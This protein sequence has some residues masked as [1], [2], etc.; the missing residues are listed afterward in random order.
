[1]KQPKHMHSV[2]DFWVY[3]GIDYRS[4]FTG[5][6]EHHWLASPK[7]SGTYRRAAVRVS[8][9]NGRPGSTAKRIG[10]RQWKVTVPHHNPGDG[11]TRPDEFIV[12]ARTRR[13]ALLL[14]EIYQ[15]YRR[16]NGPQLT[17]L[18]R[19]IVVAAVRV[20]GSVVEGTSDRWEIVLPTRRVPAPP[21][22][23]YE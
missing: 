13:K 21:K 3:Y 4:I 5:R 16:P 7:A 23:A 18:G 19:A 14:G 6:I 12:V 17:T 9:L 8:G 22:E 1:M 15:Q 2:G 11:C 20:W 10:T